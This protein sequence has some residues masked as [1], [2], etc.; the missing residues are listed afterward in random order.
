MPVSAESGE[1]RG[2]LDALL[3]IVEMMA[4]ALAAA[5]GGENLE[6]A[7]Q[8][9]LEIRDRALA[10]G[11][12][13]LAG[14]A[15]NGL[16]MVRFHQGRLGEAAGYYRQLVDLGAQ[17]KASQLPLS[18]V[19]KVG[20]AAINLEHNRL[21][22]A[23]RS[24]DEGL[25]MGRHWVGTNTLVSAAITQSR[26]RQY[27]G[28][29][30]GALEAL[31]EVER[32][33]HVRSSAP[34]VH[35]LARQRAWL[36]LVAGDFDGA[37]HLVRHLGD[38]FGQAGLEGKPPTSLEEGQQILQARLHLCRGEADL[39][40]A[41]LNQLEP[42]AEVAGRCLRIIEICMLKAMALQ[43][44]G[45][46]PAALVELSRSLDLAEPEGVRRIYLDEFAPVATLL[47][48]LCQSNEIPLRVR[49]FARE[50]LEAQDAGPEEGPPSGMVEMLTRRELQ[51]LQLMTRGLSGPEI[52]DEL[53]VAYSTVRSHM[54]SIYGKLDVHSRHEAI[55]RAKALK[56]V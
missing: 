50:L 20:L 21:A 7:F 48:R 29:A 14:H 56:L 11:N 45:N 10:S 13:F 43:A 32:L 2:E 47:A 35:R 26:L 16:A 52:A 36:R 34:A 25:R 18:A 42:A 23:A 27:S 17:R 6:K 30:Q 5:Y 8:L 38:P 33:G 31:D 51:V 3:D 9:A 49:D 53:V 37:E 55:E 4:S 54:K 28:D 46:A 12:V 39:A 40:L 15:T 24:L 41:L 1:V 19:G 22:A 44:Q